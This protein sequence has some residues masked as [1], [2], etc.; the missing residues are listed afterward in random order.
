MKEA[1]KVLQSEL[2]ILLS[3]KNKLQ[4]DLLAAD[5]RIEEIERAIQR[6]EE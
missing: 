5:K 3:V 6:L 1:I 4:H 2:E